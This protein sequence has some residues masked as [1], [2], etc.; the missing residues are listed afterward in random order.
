MPVLLNGSTQYLL[1]TTELSNTDVMSV[2]LWAYRETTSNQA[3]FS[4]SPSGSHSGQT[5]IWCSSD[6]PATVY[7]FRRPTNASVSAAAAVYSSGLSNNTWTHI[8]GVWNA[9]TLRQ[10][11]VNGVAG[12]SDST[13]ARYDE[14]LVNMDV[15]RLGDHT[16]NYYWD[17]SV[18]ELA[19]WPGE[20]FG[21]DEAD[22]LY[23]GSPLL[24]KP[25]KIEIYLP[26]QRSGIDFIGPRTISDVASP[27]YTGEHVL[28]P[29]GWPINVTR[30]AAV[31]GV[32]NPHNPFG[33]PLIGA[34]GGP[35]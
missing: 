30:D 13:A 3:C 8:L 20:V 34:F 2:S 17:G 32:T 7:V 1:E 9:D 19:V 16:P 28:A 35:V 4:V 14:A 29:L 12:T 27:T 31:G 24:V 21:Q 5:G 25:D 26:L 15:G 33:H 23:R 11:Y 18:A 22:A 10:V 6:N